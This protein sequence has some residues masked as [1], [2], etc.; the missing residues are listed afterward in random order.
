VQVQRLVLFLV[1]CIFLINPLI[2]VASNYSDGMKAMKNGNYE[3][4]VKL[5]RVAAKNGDK[6]SQH[7][8]GVMLYKGEGVNKN[9]TEASKWLNLAAKQGFSQAELDLAIIE[10]HKN[11]PNNYITENK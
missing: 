5:F 8:L 11:K 1:L 6:F 2:A 4:A 9:Y 7:C 10:Y 3:E